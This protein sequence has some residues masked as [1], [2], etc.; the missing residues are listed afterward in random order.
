MAAV[1]VTAVVVEAGSD[2][3]AAMGWAEEAEVMVE[4]AVMEAA[5]VREVVVVSGWAEAAKAAGS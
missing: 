5:A 3:V 2:L 4:V 1:M